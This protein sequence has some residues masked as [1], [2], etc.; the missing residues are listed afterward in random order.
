MEAVYGTVAH[1][2]L[3]TIAAQ[4]Q[5]VLNALTLAAAYAAEPKDYVTTTGS[6]A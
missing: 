5:H 3:T 1:V 6:L 2:D 4:F